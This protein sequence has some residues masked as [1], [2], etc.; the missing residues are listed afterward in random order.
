MLLFMGIVAGH[1]G[2]GRLAAAEVGGLL[3]DPGRY[4]Q[5]IA[6]SDPRW[7][8]A[9]ALPPGGITTRL[10]ERPLAPLLAPEMPTN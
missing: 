1:D 6:D 3:G 5:K 2:H 4:E 10:S 9:A 7:R 8:W